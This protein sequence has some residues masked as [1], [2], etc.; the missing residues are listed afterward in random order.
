MTLYMEGEAKLPCQGK[1]SYSSQPNLRLCISLMEM[2][3]QQGQEEKGDVLV[4]SQAG[5]SQSQ[6]K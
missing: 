6:T 2:H 3:T 4:H 1:E 5:Q